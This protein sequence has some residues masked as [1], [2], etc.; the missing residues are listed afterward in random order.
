MA[1]TECTME[2]LHLKR[3]LDELSLGHPAQI[4]IQCDNNGARK[5]AENPVF[6]GRSKHIDIKHHFVREVL[7]S[8]EFKIHAHTRDGC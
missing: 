4:C 5:L 6:H 3:F 8:G 7:K 2:G 1:L